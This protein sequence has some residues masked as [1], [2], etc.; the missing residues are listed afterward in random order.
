VRRRWRL[1]AVLAA[2]LLGTLDAS[3]ARRQIP[4][5]YGLFVH[6]DGE[7]KSDYSAERKSTTVQL[8]LTPPGL[9]STSSAASVVLQAGFAGREPTAPPRE[10]ALLLLPS[11]VSNPNVVRGVELD[12]TIECAGSQPLRLFYFGSSWGE[13]GYVTPGGEIT[14]V[15]FTMSA[16]ELRALTVGERVTGHAMNHSFAFTDQHLAALRLFAQTIGVTNAGGRPPA[17]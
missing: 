1:P 6:S 15:V 11:I 8:A 2:A 14:R 10:I 13:Y 7:L 12:F 16:A 17:R 5:P 4:A 3:E 9:H